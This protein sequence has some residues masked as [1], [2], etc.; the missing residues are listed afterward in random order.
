[1]KQVLEKKLPRWEKKGDIIYYNGLIYVLRNKEL[2]DWIIRLHHDSPLLG[3]P[4]EN[5]TQDMIE[6]NYWWL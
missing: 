4:G 2:R 1:V 5:C 3:H 6:H